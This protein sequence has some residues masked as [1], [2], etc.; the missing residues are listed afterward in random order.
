VLL[1]GVRQTRFFWRPVRQTRFFWRPVRQTRWLGERTLQ[2]KRTHKRRNDM[3]GLERTWSEG[4]KRK[5]LPCKGNRT[6]TTHN[7]ISVW[8]P[9][10]HQPCLLELTVSYTIQLV[11]IPSKKRL[12]EAK[13]KQ[14]S[15]ASQLLLLLGSQTNNL[16]GEDS[17][18]FSSTSPMWT[19]WLTLSLSSPKHWKY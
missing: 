19:H 8:L 7:G 1:E 9:S 3:L 10:R 15:N 6:E 18:L 12:E 4:R 2:K 13:L 5:H 16:V 17:Y 11:Y 14:T